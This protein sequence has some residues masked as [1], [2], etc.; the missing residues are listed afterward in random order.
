MV[1]R[2]VADPWSIAAVKVDVDTVLGVLVDPVRPKTCPHQGLIHRK[3]QISA[4]RIGDRVVMSGRQQVRK[5][6]AHGNATLRADDRSQIMRI[7][8]RKHLL[9]RGI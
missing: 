6:E 5:L 2:A 8:H 3:E 1:G 9:A 4:A 7:V